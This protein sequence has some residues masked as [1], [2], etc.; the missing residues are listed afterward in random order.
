MTGRPW[1]R[2]STDTASPLHLRLCSMF[3]MHQTWGAF[4]KTTSRI[5]ECLPG[6]LG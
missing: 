5:T 4:K 2:N 3:G 1:L 6:G